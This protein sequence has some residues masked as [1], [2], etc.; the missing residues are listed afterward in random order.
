MNNR[1]IVSRAALEE[2]YRRLQ[3]HARGEVAAVVKADGY[4]LGAVEVALCLA[5]AGCTEFFVASAAEGVEV[6]A[7]L[8]A[9]T[10]Y[11]LEGVWSETATILQDADLVPVLNTPAQAQAWSSSGRAAAPWPGPRAGGCRPGFDLLSD[12]APGQPLCPCR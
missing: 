5:G 9:A 8:P 1:L 12:N 2:N 4:G 6:R 7:A 10:V 3:A 11:V